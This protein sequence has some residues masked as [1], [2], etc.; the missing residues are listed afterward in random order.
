[1]LGGKAKIYREEKGNIE[2]ERN[3]IHIR[4]DSN[5][6]THIEWYWR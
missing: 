4:A 6:G 2:R 5:P 1:V 3:L